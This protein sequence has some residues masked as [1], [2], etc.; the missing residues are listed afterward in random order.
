MRIAL[1]QVLASTDPDANLDLVRRYTTDAASRGAELVVFPE[2]T[3]C[4]FARP[5]A[6]AAEP[7]DGPWASTV[8]SI[9]AEAGVTIVVG[10]FTT[11]G[12]P[13]VHN[14]LLVTGNADARY[15]KLHLFDALG[16]AE[17]RQIRAG[18]RPVAFDL[19]GH[20]F[21]LA[22]CYD[23]RFPGLFTHLA[24]SGAEAILLPASWAPGEEKLHQWR[25]LVTARAMD[26][27]TYVIAVG[28][29]LPPAPDSGPAPTGIGHSM[30]V[31]PTGTVL[32][33]LGDDPELAVI[34]LDLAAVA[35]VRE[36]LPVLQHAREHYP[37]I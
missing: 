15:D 2:A 14:T 17:S 8:R 7:F 20:R 24:R 10:M 36:R 26:A 29:A 13:Q 31:G 32:L 25:T 5:R 30:V 11:T 9:A 27:T 19:G 34:D 12:T 33:E 21:G 22:T 18:D 6:D 37:G 3:M 16:Y 4:S 23:V 28:Q 1:A 35:G